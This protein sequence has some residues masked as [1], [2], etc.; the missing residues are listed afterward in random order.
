[1]AGNTGKMTGAALAARGARMKL[2]AIRIDNR[3]VD[4]VIAREGQPVIR[5]SPDHSTYTYASSYT[6]GY[7]LKIAKVQRDLDR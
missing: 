6:L 3:I 5:W 1:M 2:I 4:F 7:L